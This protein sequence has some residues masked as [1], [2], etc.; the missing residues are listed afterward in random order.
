MLL[1]HRY[2]DIQK[3]IQDAKPEA[4]VTTPST[5]SIKALKKLNK[6]QAKLIES[7][8]GYHFVDN[9]IHWPEKVAEGGKTWQI[10]YE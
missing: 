7:E 6:T 1:E 3:K 5:A 10:E 8:K 9:N 4:I 2:N